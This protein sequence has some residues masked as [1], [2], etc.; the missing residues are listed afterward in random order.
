MHVNPGTRTRGRTA[1]LW[2]VV[3][4]W[5]T[6]AI[7]S[8]G[9]GLAILALVLAAALP[10]TLNR[11][12]MAASSRWPVVAPRVVLI[13]LVTACVSAVAVIRGGRRWGMTA[14]VV[15]GLALVASG[16]MTA[17]ISRAAS[18]AGGS[19]NP[20]NGLVYAAPGATADARETIGDTGQPAV[21]YR[22]RSGREAPIIVYAHGGGW[23]QGDAAESGHDMRWFADRGWLVISVG[24]RLATAF[25]ATWDEAHRD[26]GCALIWVRANAARWGGD[27]DRLA[28]MGDSAGGNLA[29]N[30]AYAAA[31]GRAQSSCNGAVPVPDVVVTQY[32]V[33]DPQNAY[34]HGFPV[35]DTEPRMF[36]K[37]YI[38]GTPQQFPERIRTISSAT[39]VSASAPATLIVEPDRDG[40]I[41][42]SGVLRFAEQA[43]AAGVDVTVVRIPFANHAFDQIA[44]GSLGNQASLTIRQAY[45]VRQG[46]GP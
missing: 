34:D 8:L 24:Y 42:T 41:P 32:P 26:I 18:T 5:R 30:V 13:A 38:G 46:L 9:L 15:T 2:C 37:R 14:A 33:V 19:A 31:A 36:I 35:R 45:L 43:R 6:A 3:R 21:I 16:T 22:P 12:T 40:L 17:A 25:H 27:P 1:T 23:F 44:P 7:V 29:I 10:S 4:V 20:L 28:L 11:L 39:Y